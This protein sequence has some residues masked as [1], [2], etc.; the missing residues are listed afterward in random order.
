MSKPKHILKRVAPKPSARA[1]VVKLVV[2]AKPTPKK[3]VS[4][5][6]SRAV[7]GVESA[8]QGQSPVTNTRKSYTPVTTNNFGRFLDAPMSE[9]DVAGLKMLV[10]LAGPGKIFQRKDVDAGLLRRLGE[11]GRIQ[12]VKGTPLNEL[13]QFR[14]VKTN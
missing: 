4:T 11:R 12:H 13:G 7:H 9:R 5:T 1:K 2:K 3:V 8:Y 14:V 10:K 6:V